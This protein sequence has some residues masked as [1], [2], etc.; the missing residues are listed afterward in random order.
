MIIGKLRRKESFIP[1]LD[2]HNIGKF[3]MGSFNASPDSWIIF[4]KYVGIW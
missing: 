4:C 2:G 3:P 1:K